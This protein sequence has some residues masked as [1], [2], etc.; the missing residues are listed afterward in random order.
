MRIHALKLYLRCTLLLAVLFLT[1]CGVA[2]IEMTV[3]ANDQYDLVMEM[4]VP[5]ELLV[6]SDGP[7]DLEAGFDETVADAKANGGRAGWKAL[8]SDSPDVYAYRLWTKAQPIVDD[9]GWEEIEYEGKRA[10]RFEQTLFNA[11]T[12]EGF[13]FT[14][15]AGK[16]LDS[17]GTQQGRNTVTWIDYPGTM[18]AIIKPKARFFP[19]GLIVIAAILLIGVMLFF[20]YGRVEGLQRVLRAGL[21]GGKW[22]MQA[23]KLGNDHKRLNKKKDKALT[24]LGEKSWELRIQHSDYATTFGQLQAVAQQQQAL[25][26]T[27]NTLQATIQAQT[28]TLNKTRAEFNTGIKAVEKQKQ[29]ASTTL[30]KFK[31]TGKGVDKDLRTTEKQ[32]QKTTNEI[33]AMQRRIEQLQSSPSEED[34]IQLGALRNG[35]ATL[36]TSQS[37]SEQQI[38]VLKTQITQLQQ[39][40]HPV[41]AEIQTYQQEIARLEQAQK[42]AV[43]PITEALADLETQVK[44]A[45][46]QL[47]TLNEQMPAL[48]T[49]LGTQVHHTRP[50]AADLVLFYGQVDA[51]EAALLSLSSQLD[52]VNARLAS[53]EGGNIFKFYIL[54]AFIVLSIVA[55]VVSVL[56]V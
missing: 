40:Q 33:R 19:T 23:L 30:K 5:A 20:G 18:Y 32:H 35:I 22:R 4:R 52:L 37:E 13:T 27:L 12:F 11:L 38:A 2:D 44:H 16:I 6:F 46:Q 29:A 36:K 48:L 21:S 26:Q 56:F 28:N 41:E 42:D 54:I 25:Q 24:E 8:N 31:S 53:I 15:H 34:Q 39:E 55:I 43:A 7:A 47:G 1:A 14:L 50:D 9:F 10:Y 45:Q 17:N 3:Y 49:S 51:A